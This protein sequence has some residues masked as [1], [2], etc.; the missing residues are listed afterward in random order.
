LRQVGI[1]YFTILLSAASVRQRMIMLLLVAD[2]KIR[3]AQ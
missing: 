1:P 2:C 3:P